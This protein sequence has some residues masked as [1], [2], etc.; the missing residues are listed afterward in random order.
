MYLIQPSLIYKTDP[1]FFIIGVSRS[2]AKILLY[3]TKTYCF[4]KTGLIIQRNFIDKI[5]YR[6]K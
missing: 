6:P 4:I 2:F 5:I 1:D 3:S